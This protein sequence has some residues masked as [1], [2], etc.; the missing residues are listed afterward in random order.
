MSAT[1]LLQRSSRSI[2]H[3]RRR[4][5]GGFRA[6]FVLG[7]AVPHNHPPVLGHYSVHTSAEALQAG[8]ARIREIR[9]ERQRDGRL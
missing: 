2:T 6:R 7:S 4:R 9:A 5:I 3:N 1:A 8:E